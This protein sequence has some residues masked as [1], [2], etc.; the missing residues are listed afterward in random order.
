MTDEV[1]VAKI[2]IEIDTA[3]VEPGVNR[4]KQTFKSLTTEVEQGSAKQAAA[5]AN[6]AGAVEQS[7]SRQT[8][9]SKRAIQSLET[10]TKAFGLQGEELLRWKISTRTA[11]AEQDRLNSLL[12][13][14][15]ARQKA[16]QAQMGNYGVSAKQTAAALRGVPAQLTDIAVSLQGGQRPLTVLLQQGGQL[17]DMFGGIVPA[18]KAL[19]TSLVGMINPYTL[20]AAG[21]GALALAW[22]QAEQESQA[23]SKAIILSGNA[24]GVTEGQLASM[25]AQIAESRNVTTS[26]ARDAVVAVASSGKISAENLQAVASA[27]AAMQELTGQAIDKTVADYAKLGQDPAK[28]VLDLNEKLG[29]LTVGLYEQIKALQDQG[30]Y[31]EAA[32]LATRESSEATVDALE[33]VRQSQTWIAEGW[34]TV[35]KDAD[36]AWQSMKGVLGLQSQ[37]DRRKDLIAANA[38]DMRQLAQMNSAGGANAN[39]YNDVATRLRTRTKQIEAL[40]RE[41]A[42]EAARAQVAAAQSAALTVATSLEAIIDSQASKEVKKRREIAKVT[43]E[44][45]SA[46]QKSKA[47]GQIKDAETLEAKKA[48]AIAAIEKKYADKT[49]HP[50]TAGASRSASLAGFRDDQTETKARIETET[51]TL[52]AAYQA[53]E[54]GA[55]EYYARMRELARQGTEADANTLQQQIAFLQKQTVTG[56]DAITVNKQISEL[57]A[58][59]AKVRTDGAAAQKVLTTQEKAASDA[60]QDSIDAYKASLK[61][62][63]QTLRDDMEAMIARVGAGEREYEIQQRINAARREGDRQLNQ[64]ALQQDREPQDKEKYEQLTAAVRAN[65]ATQ[66]AL[67]KAGY[68]QMAD[69]QASWALGAHAAWANYADQ[70]ANVAGQTES[71]FTN[72]FSAAEDA[73]VKFVTTGKLSFKDFANSVV[74]DI[75]RIAAKRAIAGLVGSALSGLGGGASAAATTSYGAFSPNVAGFV[76]NANGGVY[77]SPSLSAYSG[78]VIDRPT[79]FAFAKGAGL[80]GEA[81][82][83]A[84]MPLSWTPGGK[85]GVVSTGAGSMQVEINNYGG[86]TVT[87]RQET[88]RMPDGSELKKLVID[89]AAEDMASGGKLTQ[90]TKRRLDV[91]E[92]V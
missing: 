50:S 9:A 43:A 45:D 81:G 67:I 62:S 56:K 92:R 65:V 90:A 55:T 1:G 85:L 76:P 25:T 64:L 39:N 59:L 36:G 44:A 60:R 84:V 49:K 61:A 79:L 77:A 70:A 63:T 57:E 40:N 30:K 32:A 75:A 15:I 4:A 48:D 24:A 10:Q 71:L 2:A 72:A 28:N 82:P 6:V 86:S 47:A 52:Q 54:V 87:A 8:A 68:G 51:K 73:F 16:A 19:T 26:A 78:K 29:F 11:G 31:Q 69:A 83:E 22:Y 3:Q 88:T 58:K 37:A 21:A 18:A 42:P 23:Y 66:V 74:A 33:K 27:A 17:K 13:A 53:R 38:E 7:A 5:T 91:K 46:I 41:L 89:I 12:D 35:K 20:L 14:S 80:M 34:R